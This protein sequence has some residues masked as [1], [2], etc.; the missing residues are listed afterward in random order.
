MTCGCEH[1]RERMQRVE[2]ALDYLMN[3]MD[4]GVRRRT[5]TSMVLKLDGAST[6]VRRVDPVKLLGVPAY[7]VFLADINGATLEV[8]VNGE[9]YWPMLDGDLIDHETI[10]SLKFNVTG[11]GSGDFIIRLTAYRGGT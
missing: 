4:Q 7:G 10:T 8:S 1:D 9:D 11:A 6:G 5:N 2:G 3:A